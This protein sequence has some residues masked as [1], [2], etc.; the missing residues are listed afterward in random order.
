MQLLATR[1]SFGLPVT[2]NHGDQSSELGR[3]A[4]ALHLFLQIKLMVVV[5]DRSDSTLLR[6]KLLATGVGRLPIADPW[7]CARGFR[8]AEVVLCL[9]LA[10]QVEHSTLNDIWI[11]LILLWEHFLYLWVSCHQSIQLLIALARL[12]HLR[13]RKVVR[14]LILIGAKLLRIRTECMG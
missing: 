13:I 5:V 3:V 10:R 11:S 14:S 7:R 12:H 9:L 4:K 2:L 8:S 1:E 6:L